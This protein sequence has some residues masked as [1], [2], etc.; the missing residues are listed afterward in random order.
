[1]AN[2]FILSNKIYFTINY[3][4][5]LFCSLYSHFAI[6][7]AD[8]PVLGSYSLHRFLIEIIFTF[9]IFIEVENILCMA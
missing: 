8:G 2:M 3:E 5:N 4:R 7:W 9:H 1:M 6:G